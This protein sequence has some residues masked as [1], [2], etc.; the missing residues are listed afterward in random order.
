MKLCLPIALSVALLGSLKAT[1]LENGGGPDIEAVD[2]RANNNNLVTRLVLLKQVKE[3]QEPL[4]ALNAEIYALRMEMG[5][6]L[7]TLAKYDKLKDEQRELENNIREK[8]KEIEKWAI[9]FR[10]SP[11][12]T[13]TPT[14]RRRYTA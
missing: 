1:S 7:E 11:K 9:E 2:R 13:N 8:E 14:E 10:A 4:N 3:L 5:I 12:A 6:P